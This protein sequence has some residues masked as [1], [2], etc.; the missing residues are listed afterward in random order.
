MVFIRASVAGRGLFSHSLL[1]FTEQKPKLSPWKRQMT[2][3][4]EITRGKNRET[5]LFPLV[6][7]S[8]ERRLPCFGQLLQ[9]F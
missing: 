9:F 2:K 7:L 1:K 6:T 4:R 8:V 3:Q 5:G